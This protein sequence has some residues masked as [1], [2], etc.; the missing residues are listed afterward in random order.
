MKAPGNFFF[1]SA[2]AALIWAGAAPAQAQQPPDP[3]EIIACNFLEGSDASDLQ[4][5]MNALNEWMDERNLDNFNISTL[6]P[7]FTSEAFTYD[8][9]FFNRWLDG[10]ALGQNFEAFFGPDGDEAVEGFNGVVDCSSSALFAGVLLEPPGEARN[11]GPTQFLNCTVKENRTVGEA[12]GAINAWVEATNESGTDFGT[13]HAVL[14]PLAG[15]TPEASYNFK[16]LVLFESFQAYGDSLDGLLAP[17]GPSLGDIIEPVM[18]CDSARI[19]N[20][21][22]N[23]QAQTED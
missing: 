3:I 7:I 12:I 14:F 19:Y 22:I 2:L 17:G 20:Q 13:G 18:D 10:N 15:E 6:V 1:G 21:M 9:L 23:R 8:V 4:A 16:W 11:G 5:P